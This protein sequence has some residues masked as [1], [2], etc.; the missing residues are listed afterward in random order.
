MP[1]KIKIPDIE[2]AAAAAYEVWITDAGKSGDPEFNLLSHWR[3]DLWRRIAQAA[4]QSQEV[5]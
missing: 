4:I 3:R 2:R 1:R 5:A